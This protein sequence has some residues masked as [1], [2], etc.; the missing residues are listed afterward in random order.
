MKV[1][2]KNFQFG[3]AGN[4]NQP[5]FFVGV[6]GGDYLLSIYMTSA[7]GSSGSGSVTFTASWPDEFGNQSSPSVVLLVGSSGP[8]CAPAVFPI[9]ATSLSQI[10]YATVVASLPVGAVYDMSVA[11]IDLAAPSL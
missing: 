10:Q 5:N 8:S 3:L 4:I 2:A 1:V 6:D 9:R 11:L 7:G